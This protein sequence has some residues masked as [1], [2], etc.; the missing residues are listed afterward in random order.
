MPLLSL[1]SID[2]AIV[3]AEQPIRKVRFR[4]WGSILHGQ[5]GMAL[6][7][8]RDIVSAI[9]SLSISLSLLFS[10]TAYSQQ[11]RNRPLAHSNPLN[12]EG[13]RRSK[14]PVQV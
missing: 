12:H 11:L 2:V 3:S 13:S 7:K 5:M 10:G 6:A 1:R 9:L 8:V 14:E 4:M